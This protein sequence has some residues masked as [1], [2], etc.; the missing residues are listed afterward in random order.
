ML[1]CARLAGWVLAF[2]CQLALWVAPAI[3]GWDVCDA[4][5]GLSFRTGDNRRRLRSHAMLAN[6][7]ATITCIVA[8][9]F[10]Y[11]QA[12]SGDKTAVMCRVRDVQTASWVFLL[13]Y[14]AEVEVTWCWPGRT[15]DVLEACILPLSILAEGLQRAFFIR[16]IRKR[17]RLTE[18]AF[19]EELGA[20]KLSLARN[21]VGLGGL[22]V[23]IIV[24][25]GAWA[26]AVH[27]AAM[28][29]ISRMNIY[30]YA[31]FEL[32]SCAA[33]LVVAVASAGALSH[34]IGSAQDAALG[35]APYVQAEATWAVNVLSRLRI[36]TVGPC[37]VDCIMLLLMAAATVYVQLAAAEIQLEA[38]AL[39]GTVL[40]I[41]STAPVLV[42]S[43]GVFLIAGFFQPK[44]PQITMDC[45]DGSQMGRRD[46]EAT[47]GL[48]RTRDWHA[49]VESLAYRSIALVDILDVFDA[50]A[51]GCEEMP[52]YDPR[53]STTSDVVRQ[54]IIPRSRVGDGGKAYADVMSMR[55]QNPPDRMVTHCWDCPFV[56]IVAAAVASAQHQKVF[57]DI[58]EELAAVGTQ[59][60][61]CTLRDLGT[62]QMSFWICC[63]C[64]NQ[65]AHICHSS[66]HRDTVSGGLFPT[67]SCS[68]RKYTN[69]TDPEKCELNK[70]D[71]VMARMTEDFGGIRHLVV[72]DREF[73]IFSR[74]WC[75][76]ELVEGFFSKLPVDLCVESMSFMND[77]ADMETYAKVAN[78]SVVHCH[79][80]REEDKEYILSKIPNTGQ[81]DA[82]LQ[83]IVFGHDGLLGQDF[84]G[85]G[86]S[87]A[88]VRVARRTAHAMASRSSS[89]MA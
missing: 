67:C 83:K 84:E 70:F 34:V 78:T 33:Q 74:A 82:Q 65:H 4:T 28:A 38:D 42:D 37:L 81:F 25:A 73:K 58:A 63:F 8:L 27:G 72:S 51:E 52:H 5:G 71:D 57:G 54:F 23:A 53:R 50:L 59:P 61:R 24:T 60:A 41:A 12:R 13:V 39:Q 62:L 69:T 30:A 7:S 48:Q 89:P 45:P 26:F 46:D 19:E 40:L 16:A 76:A 21:A 49:T 35:G 9:V 31:T 44:P 55:K 2:L 1:R 77:L 43:L 88:A 6:S 66:R 68:Q 79:A 10:R 64:V 80:S 85:F 86:L 36:A 18:I 20:H 47:A 11:L 29:T 15:G 32:V 17:V 56:Q 3:R 75:V 87:E 22:V 14:T